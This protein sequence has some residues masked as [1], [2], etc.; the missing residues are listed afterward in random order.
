MRRERGEQA[1]LNR[2]KSQ[3]EWGWSG[4]VFDVFFYVFERFF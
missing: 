1:V 2:A 4:P 3:R